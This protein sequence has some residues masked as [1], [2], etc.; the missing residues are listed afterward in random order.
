[1]HSGNTKN[2]T[3]KTIILSYSANPNKM[4]F[5]LPEKSPCVAAAPSSV[6]LSVAWAAYTSNPQDRGAPC[7][8]GPPE[9]PPHRWTAVVICFVVVNNRAAGHDLRFDA[10][11][12]APAPA[13][14][15]NGPSD[16]GARA[17]VD[18]QP[19][20]DAEVYTMSDGGGACSAAGGRPGLA[21]PHVD[22][23]V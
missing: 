19:P 12:V 2:T 13:R 17:A 3:E 23:S 9:K 10:R 22:E 6:H 7:R 21:S 4:F 1:M 8:G 20:R 16:G 11:R 14:E 18:H 5:F 15:P